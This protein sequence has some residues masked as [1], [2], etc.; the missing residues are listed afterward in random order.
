MPTITLRRQDGSE[1]NTVKSH[2]LVCHAGAVTHTLH[3]HKDS[4]GEWAVSDPLSGGK[5]LRVQGFYKGCPVS[6]KGLTI[7]EARGLAQTQID[8]LIE[9]VGSDRF[10]A[11]LTA[12]I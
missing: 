6:T 5:V 11:I 4:V 7:A 8:D 1:I 3:L 2:L 12:F 10:N 9:R